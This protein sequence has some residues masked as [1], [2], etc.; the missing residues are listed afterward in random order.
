M[1]PDEDIFELEE[2]EEKSAS[3]VGVTIDQHVSL[4]QLTK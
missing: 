2:R 1:Q 3:A 4:S